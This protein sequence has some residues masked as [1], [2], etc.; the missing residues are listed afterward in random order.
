VLPVFVLMVSHIL[1]GM[2]VMIFM[3]SIVIGAFFRDLNGHI[4]AFGVSE[5]GY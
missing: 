5:V 4:A 3:Y 1:F 2:I